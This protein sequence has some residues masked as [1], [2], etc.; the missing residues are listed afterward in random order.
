MLRELQL[1]YRL[2][3]AGDLV[4]CKWSKTLSYVDINGHLFTSDIVNTGE[5][6]IFIT[7]WGQNLAMYLRRDGQIRYAASHAFEHL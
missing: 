1:T 2:M 6:F 5:V 7:K 4:K 3:L